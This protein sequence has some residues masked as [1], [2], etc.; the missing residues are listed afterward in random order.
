MTQIIESGHVERGW[1][2][3]EAQD[4]TPQLAESFG[5]KDIHGMLI[6]GVLRGGPADQAGIEPGDVVDRL[7]DRDVDSARAAMSRIAQAG[8]GVKLK[9][10]GIRDGKRLVITA[11]TGRRPEDR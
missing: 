4:L 9:L 10:E 5:L 3:I 6:A 8:P 1:L 11:T 7:D 2:G